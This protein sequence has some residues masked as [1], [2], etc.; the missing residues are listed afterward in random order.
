MTYQRAFSQKL[1][2]IKSSTDQFQLQEDV[3]CVKAW[4]KKWQMSFNKF[5]CY[6]I[7]VTHEKKLIKTTYKMDGIPLE[8]VDSYPYLGVEI[9][10]DLN[11]A[12]HMNEISNKAN[13]MLGLTEEKHI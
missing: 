6:S 1:K 9:S 12:S 3:D 7:R 4:E 2:E 13:R 5:K 10:K 8:E 11:W